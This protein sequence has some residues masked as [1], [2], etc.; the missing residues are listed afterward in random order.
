MRLTANIRQS[1]SEIKRLMIYDSED[2]VYLFGYDNYEDSGSLWDSWFE[3]IEDAIE[4]CEEDYEIA[5]SDWEKIPDP[6]ENCQHDWI[7]PV[8]VKGRD[9]GKPEWGKLE[10]LI[11]RKWIEV[12]S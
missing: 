10:K 4:S 1:D 2:G 7:E 12:K 5:K 9:I 6:L 3:S 8:R 11:D